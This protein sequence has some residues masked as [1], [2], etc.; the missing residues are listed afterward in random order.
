M[1]VITV[2]DLREQLE[3]LE[4]AGMADALV[5]FRDWYN[6]DHEVAEGIVDTHENIVFLG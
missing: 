2:K 1:K 4:R 6:F 5:W 3:R